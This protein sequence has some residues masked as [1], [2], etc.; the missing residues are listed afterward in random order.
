MEC[1]T[2]GK[3]EGKERIGGFIVNKTRQIGVGM[4]TNIGQGGGKGDEYK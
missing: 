2:C 3:P 4:T 1:E